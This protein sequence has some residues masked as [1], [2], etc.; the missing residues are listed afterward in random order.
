VTRIHRLVVMVAFLATLFGC[1]VGMESLK[2][3]VSTRDDVFRV[4]GRAANEWQQPDGST[5]IEFT[6]QPEGV[7]NWFIAL[8]PDGRLQSITQVLTDANF[9][10]IRPGMTK[11]EV[12][13]I[14]GSPG[15]KATFPLKKEEVWSW[16]YSP[17]PGNRFDF[18]VHFD[19]GGKVVS[20]SRVSADVAG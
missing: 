5:V 20:T 15:P 10:R 9:Q 6:R 17:Q 7:V 13:R 3:G 4:M 1:D 8:G 2:P 18:N 19:L 11:D 16:R 14:I 12:V